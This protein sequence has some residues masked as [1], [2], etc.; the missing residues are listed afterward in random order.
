MA[1]N[2]GVL[3]LNTKLVRMAAGRESGNSYYLLV[4]SRC[5]HGDAIC[6]TP[7]PEGT[8]FRDGTPTSR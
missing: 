5:H 1:K 7:G 4:R 2:G 3:P 6:A 8:S